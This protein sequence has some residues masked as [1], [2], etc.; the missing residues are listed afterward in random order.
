MFYAYILKSKKNNSYYIGSC[1][2]V[3]KRLRQHNSGKVKSTK[4]FMPWRLVYKENFDTRSKAAKR[5]RQLKSWKSRK[6][7]EKL[8]KEHY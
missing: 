6:A 2:D 7:L 1:L 5:E 8:I 3:I 4:R